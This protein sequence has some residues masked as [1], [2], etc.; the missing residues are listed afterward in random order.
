M[1]AWMA[2]FADIIVRGGF[3]FARFRYGKWDKIRV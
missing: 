2:M 3:F 1:G